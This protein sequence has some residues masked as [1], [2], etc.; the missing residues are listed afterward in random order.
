[1]H[2]TIFWGTPLFSHTIFLQHHYVFLLAECHFILFSRLELEGPSTILVGTSLGWTYANEE[3][4]FLP[5]NKIV[6]LLAQF[7]K[8]IPC[9]YVLYTPCEAKICHGL[10]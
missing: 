7:S 8:I 1:M 5:R 2:W 3:T 4:P 10:M 9:W 6:E